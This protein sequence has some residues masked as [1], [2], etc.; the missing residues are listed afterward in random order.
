MG[1]VQRHEAPHVR[2]EKRKAKFAVDKDKES[3]DIGEEGSIRQYIRYLN[4][5]RLRETP[6]NLV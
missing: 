6:V 1:S 3:V 2:T 5:L 4:P